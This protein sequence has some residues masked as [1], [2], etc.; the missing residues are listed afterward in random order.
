M[1][2][3]EMFC[4]DHDLKIDIDLLFD[5]DSHSTMKSYEN[6][7]VMTLFDFDPVVDNYDHV[8]H[9]KSKEEF[10]KT[11]RQLR[12]FA[13]KHFDFGPA[14]SFGGV[15]GEFSASMMYNIPPVDSQ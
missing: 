5:F 8:K 11:A 15:D 10:L 3:C 14:G 9:V 2:T 13:Q 4:F 1:E 6:Y 12:C 7:D